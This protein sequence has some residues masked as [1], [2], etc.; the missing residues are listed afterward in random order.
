MCEPTGFL[1]GNSRRSQ[2]STSL[3]TSNSFFPH[4]IRPSNSRS[5]FPI[6]SPVPHLPLSSQAFAHLLIAFTSP[7]LK[8]APAPY[9]KF[10]T[11]SSREGIYVSL[12]R[13]MTKV[14]SSIA[15]RGF[16]FL[17]RVKI[18]LFN[19]KTNKND[20]EAKHRSHVYINLQHRRIDFLCPP[21][22]V[23]VQGRYS[24]LRS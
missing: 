22:F 4:T 16:L 24:P 3:N 21:V 2:P 23:R 17:K 7:S 18:R 10:V 15:P 19:N 5:H 20:P 1:L 8:S 11:G 9:S 6:L 12:M 13:L 14:Q